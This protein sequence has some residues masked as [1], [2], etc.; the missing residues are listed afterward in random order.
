VEW[1]FTRYGAVSHAVRHGDARGLITGYV[2]ND[3]KGIACAQIENV[4]WDELDDER[5]AELLRVFLARVA[6]KA[7]IAVMPI[8][9]YVD[10]QI[11]RKNG[12][13]R[14]A[15]RLNLYLALWNGDKVPESLDSVYIDIL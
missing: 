6:E 13:R 8:C 10:V 15:R 12:F 4:F 7:Q 9:N 11:F 2:L 14:S 3:T 5:K 1:E